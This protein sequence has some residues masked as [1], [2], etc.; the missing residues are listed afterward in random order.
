MFNFEHLYSY[1]HNLCIKFLILQSSKI[2]LCEKKQYFKRWT[3]VRNLSVL[4]IDVLTSLIRSSMSVNKT[5]CGIFF[6]EI[7]SIGLGNHF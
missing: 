2:S 5:H 1:E 6:F 4:F 7:P 3:A